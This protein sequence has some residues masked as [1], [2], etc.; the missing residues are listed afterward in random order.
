[1]VN[2]LAKLWKVAFSGYFNILMPTNNALKEY[3]EY[4]QSLE[5]RIQK[6]EETVANLMYKGN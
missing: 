3:D 2:T 4:I 1:M 6:L 5:K